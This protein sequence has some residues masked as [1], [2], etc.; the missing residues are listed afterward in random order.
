M[1]KRLPTI[2]PQ[3]NL[4]DILKDNKMKKKSEGEEAYKLNEPMLHC[5]TPEG[6]DNA[7]EQTPICQGGI[8]DNSAHGSAYPLHSRG[9]YRRSYSLIYTCL[10]Q[11]LN[12]K[13]RTPRIHAAPRTSA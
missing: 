4:V 13:E 10:M 12:W 11:L 6:N 7:R 9:D 5:S 2:L 8:V 1:E 3:L